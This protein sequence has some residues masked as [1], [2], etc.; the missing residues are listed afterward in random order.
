MLNCFCEFPKLESPFK[1]EDI[2]TDEDWKL[3]SEDYETGKVNLHSGSIKWFDANDEMAKA[4]GVQRPEFSGVGYPTNKKF[5]KL[6]REYV[7]DTLPDDFI[8]QMWKTPIG[9]KLYPCTLLAWGR[10]SDWHTEGVVYDVQKNPKIASK[11][12][13]TVINFRLLGD[14][15]N[16]KIKFADPSPVLHNK[17][18]EL[19]EMFVSNDVHENYSAQLQSISHSMSNNDDM[20]SSGAKRVVSYIGDSD[21]ESASE[22][23]E[24]QKTLNY[25]AVEFVEED[26]LEI[27]SPNDIITSQRWEDE[28]NPITVKEGFNSPFML[29]LARWHKVVVGDAGTRV[30]LRLMADR[31]VPF[32][33][34]EEMVDNGTFFK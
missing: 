15:D 22:V 1:P 25:K 33:H 23:V 26:G 29:N 12:Y 5:M 4:K 31:N 11:R 19:S 17:I 6:L 16:S 2:F 13:S 3:F 14:A 27:S 18:K 32:S 24:R 20:D 7:G 10:D 21:K 8:K 30:T 28:L 34:W 9:Q